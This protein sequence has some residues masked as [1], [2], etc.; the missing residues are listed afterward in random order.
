M[1]EQMEFPIGELE[2]ELKQ[3]LVERVMKD[4]P[5]VGITA[6]AAMALLEAVSNKVA[7]CKELV[8]QYKKTYPGIMRGGI[9]IVMAAGLFSMEA[10]DPMGMMPVEFVEGYRGAAKNLVAKLKEDVEE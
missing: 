3:G 8:K 5:D 10:G 6:M 2:Q 9:T 7:E 1:E 4:N